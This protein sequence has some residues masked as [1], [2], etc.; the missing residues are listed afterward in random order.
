MMH[1]GW[2]VSEVVV[3]VDPTLTLKEETGLVPTGEDFKL[4]LFHFLMFINKKF[5]RTCPFGSVAF[6]NAWISFPQL[7][8][9]HEFCPAA[10]V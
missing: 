10:G 8:R 6:L 5:N 4:F 2:Q 1:L 7:L 9:Q 3:V